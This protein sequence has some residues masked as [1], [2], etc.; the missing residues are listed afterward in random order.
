[1]NRSTVRAGF[2]ATIVLLFF[3]AIPV[4]ADQTPITINPGTLQE[5]LDA[6]SKATD[7]KIVYLNELIEGKNSPGV[8]N[9]SPD[10]ALEQILQGTGLSFQM[11]DNNTAVLKKKSTEKQPVSEQQEPVSPSL[12]AE[13]EATAVREMESVTVTA[14]KVEEDLQK[15]PQSITVIND[16]ILKEKEIEDIPDVINEISNMTF[17][18]S[19][20]D[21]VNFRGLNKSAFT[22]N[23]PV[24]IYIDGV[25]YS[26]S[27][28][29]DA[30]LN[31]VER[32]EVL[33]GPQGT[34]YGKD[35]IGAV[36]K[37]V[38]KE[39]EN[40]WH[41]NIGTEYGSYNDIEGSFNVNGPL[42]QDKF[43]LG[44]NARYQQ[45]N[46]WIT[47]DYTSD[48]DANKSENHNLGAF[49][50][51]KPTD[52]FSAKFILSDDYSEDYGYTGYA[53]PSGADISEFDRDDAEHVSVDEDT[54]YENEALAQS[55]HLK[56][57][58]DSVTLSST[59]TH[60][61]LAFDGVWDKDYMADT[62]NDGL[63]SFGKTDTET[64]TEEIRLES[65]NTE[66]LRWVAGAYFDIEDTENMPTGIQ[67]YRS[68]SAYE[69]KWNTETKSK[70]LALFGQTMI[71][72]GDSFELTLGTRY[73]HI[74]KKTDS[75]A[76]Y[77]Q[78]GGSSD[79]YY[80]FHGDE[81][82]DVLLPKAALSYRLNDNWT[83]Y[84][85]VAQGYMP[86]G[87]TTLARYGS[88]EDN[89]FDP[90]HSTNYEIGVKGKFNRAR[91]AASVF[92]MDIEDT[93]FSKYV[94]DTWVTDNA[95]SSHSMGAELELTYFL[96]DSI[97]LTAALG[98][99]EAEY[100][101][102]DNGTVVWDGESIQ[103]TPSYSGQIGAAYYHPNGFYARGDVK[104]QGEVPYY[105]SV[106]AEFREIDNYIT[107]NVKIGY[108]FKGYDI[109]AFCNNLTDEEYITALNTGGKTLATYGDPRTFGIGVRYSF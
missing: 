101:E 100:D 47:N 45:D 51:Y 86:G 29:F 58:F 59:T 43:Y 63:F 69:M 84:A 21:N 89:T 1:M 4:M 28:G 99:I 38:T 2:C 16:E 73:Q 68:G 90:Q 46:G 6:Y 31:N 56:Y 9:A 87:F 77:N 85:S 64:W 7:T 11:A 71:P 41:G 20:D 17:R 33:R 34:I 15:V 42:I 74:D 78:I 88:E 93:Q 61:D 81:T 22:G 37:V 65:N 24:V 12:D 44:L 14:N 103:N 96:T 94:N 75:D 102:Y 32:I 83:T 109:Y 79:P 54:I 50:L 104:C 55:L 82:W 19:I 40:Q 108:R 13:V 39:P 105:D 36:I 26:N 91:L 106:N 70:T 92:Y 60:R 27:G 25:A 10:D 62:A 107:A 97:E 49:L 66:G 72:L 57:K 98:I 52:R 18:S 53:L 35:A 30:S 8:Q 80:S 76:Y 5:A 67:V 3:L 95:D 48:D 23:N